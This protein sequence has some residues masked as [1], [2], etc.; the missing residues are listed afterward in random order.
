M[1]P[2]MQSR[3]T[4]AEAFRKRFVGFDGTKGST[5]TQP[6]NSQTL[7]MASPCAGPLIGN[8][9][10]QLNSETQLRNT[11]RVFLLYSQRIMRA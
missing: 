1:D 11:I 2:G 8:L 3:R 9:K 7:Y 10:T 4:P 5:G 6:Q